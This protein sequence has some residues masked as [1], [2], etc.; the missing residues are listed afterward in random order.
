MSTPFRSTRSSNTTPES[1][2]NNTPSKKKLNSTPVIKSASKRKAVPTKS[3]AKSKRNKK[4]KV[5][6]DSEATEST[7]DDEEEPV[8]QEVSAPAAAVNNGLINQL[9]T[10]ETAID[11]EVDQTAK[12]DSQKNSISLSSDSAETQE[13]SL[14]PVASIVEES[15]QTSALNQPD[16]LD[17]QMLQEKVIKEMAAEF[18]G[19]DKEM[20]IGAMKKAPKKKPIEC[21]KSSQAQAVKH[22][23]IQSLACPILSSGDVDVCCVTEFLLKGLLGWENCKYWQRNEILYGTNDLL[24]LPNPQWKANFQFV[25]SNTVSANLV[26]DTLFDK[27]KLGAVNEG[28][29]DEKFLLA[30][31]PQNMLNLLMIATFIDAQI[32]KWSSNPDE[33]RCDPNKNT[34]NSATATF[35]AMDDLISQC[36]DCDSWMYVILDCFKYC[37]LKL[38]QQFQWY[39]SATSFAGTDAAAGT[40]TAGT[41]P[42]FM[43]QKS[44][45]NSGPFANSPQQQLILVLKSL[46]RQ[47]GWS[48][49]LPVFVSRRTDVQLSMPLQKK[50]T[51]NCNFEKWDLSELKR[52]YPDILLFA[53]LDKLQGGLLY[54]EEI[55]KWID[56]RVMAAA[57]MAIHR[58]DVQP[59]NIVPYF[60]LICAPS[61]QIQSMDVEQWMRESNDAAQFSTEERKD[62]VAHVY[63]RE[64]AVRNNAPLCQRL[65]TW[66]FIVWMDLTAAFGKSL[67]ES[68]YNNLNK[69]R[70][71]ADVKCARYDELMGKYFLPFPQIVIEIKPCTRYMKQF[72]PKEWHSN[73]TSVSE[74]V[75]FDVVQLADS[76]FQVR[77]FV[78]VYADEEPLL[79]LTGSTNTI[80]K[81]LHL[82]DES[83]VDSRQQLPLHY[84]RLHALYHQ[85]CA[86]Y[87]LFM[88]QVCHPDYFSSINID[89]V[90]CRTRAN[91][92]CYSEKTDRVVK[93]V[94]DDQRSTSKVFGKILSLLEREMHVGGSMW[95]RN[96]NVSHSGLGVDY[97]S[98][99]SKLCF[100]E[101]Y[102]TH[103]PAGLSEQP[104]T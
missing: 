56:Q 59:F 87:S 99:I 17:L 47:F 60:N 84:S 28:V 11:A 100:S 102:Q 66:A 58:F 31:E 21:C 63:S 98:A 96:S 76:R 101:F 91:L 92:D 34:M 40:A 48:S 65:A 36:A 3:A 81:I 80:R 12:D 37:M 85:I 51:G 27:F 8:E 23:F 20:D 29:S 55:R 86:V 19:I 16:A 43:F 22:L 74:V 89:V 30:L 33:V 75:N 57:N 32:C 68:I 42:H 2:R 10:K 62:L 18:D 13:Y 83:Q 45:R 69:S 103:Y 39:M 52:D 104:T 53:M 78:N 25:R 49:P 64:I 15:K 46:H 67:F 94:A 72:F 73:P 7:A 4:N 61:Y 79:D 90:T 82:D 97:I 95:L 50:K 93:L 44:T 88:A 1:D 41:N 6:S 54:I 24:Q 26:Q 77:L 70:G 5:V 14:P 71:G 35:S 38:N 9:E